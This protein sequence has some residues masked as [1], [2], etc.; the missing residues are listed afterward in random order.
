MAGRPVTKAA[1]GRRRCSAVPRQP[2]ESRAETYEVK[3]W[4][5][6]VPPLDRP[7]PEHCVDLRP[8]E[9]PFRDGLHVQAVAAA[10]PHR[11]GYRTSFQS[12]EPSVDAFWRVSG[13]SAAAPVR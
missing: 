3:A 12:C 7:R 8:Q 9:L 4:T 6:N 5:A 2:Q 10:T 11:P 1:G 13:A